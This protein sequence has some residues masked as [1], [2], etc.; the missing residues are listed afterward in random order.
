M[1]LATNWKRHIIPEVFSDYEF[2]VNW[3]P[4]LIGHKLRVFYLKRQLKQLG[5]RPQIGVGVQFIGTRNI[6]I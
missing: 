3:A 1:G 2:V 4:G 5:D 6:M